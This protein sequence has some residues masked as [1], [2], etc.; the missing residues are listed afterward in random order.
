MQKTLL[1]IRAFFVLIC[2][3]GGWLV[4]YAVVSWDE[5]REIGALIGFLIG[6]LVVLVDFLLKGFSLRALSAISFG[7]AIGTL[8]SW[9]V[10]SS[11]LFAFGDPVI[12]HMT[13]I[14]LFVIVT[15]LC[16]VIALRGK[17]EFN[18]IIPYVRFVPQEVEAQL[19]LIDTGVLIDGRISKVCACGFLSGAL[20]LPQFILDELQGV[21]DSEDPVRQARGRRGL[22]VLNE[23]RR[24][25]NIDIRIVESDV[26]RRGDVD[27]KLVFLAQSMKARLL[28]LDF[29]LAKLA[30]FHGVNCLNLG[31]LSKALMPELAVG[32][33]IE[34][35]LVK[36]GKEE[37]QAI[38]YL[39]DGSMV[40]ASQ[41][42]SQV[43]RRVVVE[44]AS[45]LPSAGGKMVF[46]R[47]LRGAD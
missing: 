26:S 31:A 42:R 16:T 27:A 30:E 18:L 41:A 4:C 17:D 25:R 8:I 23:L 3:L 22:D 5:F 28:T 29:N 7:L 13:R 1:I 32:E 12:V 34:V 21:A 14:G 6:A 10:V 9:F 24:V 45:I 20:V 36:A 35:E 47:F 37:G 38:G 46:A 40:V 33:H 19:V 11:P 2:A 44:I 43:G 39:A 15:Y